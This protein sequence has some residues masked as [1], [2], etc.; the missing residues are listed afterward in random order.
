MVSGTPLEI[1]FAEQAGSEEDRAWRIQRAALGL[2]QAAGDAWPAAAQPWIRRALALLLA[3]DFEGCL[4]VCADLCA[5][6]P[7]PSEMSREQL[8]Q[9][10]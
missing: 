6:E 1:W 5:T 9:Q 8:E 10:Q 3:G 7:W 2:R 4:A